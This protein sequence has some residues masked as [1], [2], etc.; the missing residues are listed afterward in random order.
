MS[1]FSSDSSF[2]LFDRHGDLCND[3]FLAIHSPILISDLLANKNM[4]AE[5]RQRHDFEVCKLNVARVRRTKT[6]LFHSCYHQSCVCHRNWH[7]NDGCDAVWPQASVANFFS[8]WF[9]L[10]CSSTLLCKEC[11]PLSV[12]VVVVVRVTTVLNF[13]LLLLSFWWNVNREQRQ[14]SPRR[15]FAHT[16]TQ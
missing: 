9:S 1:H 16:H 14:E 6:E 5:R 4:G 7:L 2:R 3:L 11:R 15:W 12:V 8:F 10:V 13:G